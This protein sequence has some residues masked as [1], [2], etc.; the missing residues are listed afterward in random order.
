MSL[1][2]VTLS[3][4]NS[5]IA[6]I[7]DFGASTSASAAANKTAIDAALTY[8]ASNNL[9]LTTVSTGTFEVNGTISVPANVRFIGRENGQKPTLKWG[10]GTAPSNLTNRA[11]VTLAGA[12]SAIVGW[13]I[14]MST[15]GDFRRTIS[16]GGFDNQVCQYNKIILALTGVNAS[17][18]HFTIFCSAASLFYNANISYNEITGT[19]NSGLDGIQMSFSVNASILNN[20]I[21]DITRGPDPGAA[22]GDRFYWG[23]YCSQKC[24]GLNVSGNIVRDTNTSGI[25]ISNATD[26][27]AN[28]YGRRVSNNYIDTV[29]WV[30]LSLDE[31][32]GAVASGNII[33]TTGYPVGIIGCNSLTY[34]GGSISEMV[35]TSP[36][37]SANKPMM[38]IITSSVGTVISGVTFDVANDALICI[39]V[40]SS[41]TSIVGITSTSE[42][43]VT[44]IQTSS[45]A[46]DISI[47]G[48]V[49]VS[50]TLTTSN[51]RILIA[52]DSTIV[53]GCR[54]ACSATG[55]IGIRVNGTRNIIN[56]NRVT[57]GTNGIWLTSTSSNTLAVNNN[58]SGSSSTA[59]L[60]SGT[61]NTLANN[62]T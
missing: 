62:L 18:T 21:H 46:T 51:S 13:N 3:M 1:T 6:C 54:I 57:G 56:G 61:T 44:V 19:G 33:N 8:A 59:I 2:Q 24:Y 26:G 9:T 53:E 7:E 58:V 17:V 12:N 48:V 5:G 22:G 47:K 30:G 34:T 25:R 52:K 11:A 42:S 60:D 43:P 49:A 4:L 27:V 28:D 38:D 35:D 10:A 45:T 15:N 14:D 29:I 20:Y 50:P 55:Q 32:N 16:M 31:L 41:N 36:L 23:I 37:V 40:D 39:Y